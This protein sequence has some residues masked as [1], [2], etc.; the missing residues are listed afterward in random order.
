MVDFWEEEKRRVTLWG[1][2]SVLPPYQILVRSSGESRNDEAQSAVRDIRQHYID[3]CMPCC[4]YV[5]YQPTCC[6]YRST[7]I[8]EVI[9]LSLS[10]F[11]RLYREY[12][13]HWNFDRT[14][15]IHRW[16][17]K[18]RENPICLRVVHFVLRSRPH[19]VHRA[20]M[21]FFVCPLE[22]ESRF[23]RLPSSLLPQTKFY[24]QKELLKSLRVQLFLLRIFYVLQLFWERAIY[25]I[26]IYILSSMQ[27][28]LRVSFLLFFMRVF[29]RRNFFLSLS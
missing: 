1:I 13:E 8:G 16:L 9:S 20:W 17:F 27:I 22:R 25:I 26:A 21:W 15:T 24:K 23:L 14:V 11:R 7:R 5:Y 6:Q 12:D 18:A 19:R 2:G 29:F 3:D 4:P 28:V 10:F